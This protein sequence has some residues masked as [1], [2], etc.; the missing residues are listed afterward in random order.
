MDTLV[1]PIKTGWFCACSKPSDSQP[2]TSPAL[3]DFYTSSPLPFMWQDLSK[4]FKIASALR[5]IDKDFSPPNGMCCT[6][7]SLWVRRLQGAVNYWKQEPGAGREAVSSLFSGRQGWDLVWMHTHTHF[8]HEWLQDLHFFGFHP[9][10][11]LLFLSGISPPGWVA[12]QKFRIEN[13]K[14]SQTRIVTSTV[15]LYSGMASTFSFSFILTV[16]HINPLSNL[17]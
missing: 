11:F 15:Q 2:E 10:V 14:L 4:S 1:F 16:T 13:D 12:L 9:P 6:G 5:I 7:L 17:I 3:N 8:I